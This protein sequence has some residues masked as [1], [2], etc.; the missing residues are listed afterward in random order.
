MPEKTRDKLITVANELFYE[1]GFHAVGLDQVLE[2]VGVTKT[3]FYNHFESKDE[4][5]IAVL[6]ERDR[7]ELAEWM[8]I[9]EQKGGDDPRARILALFDLLE[10]W[11]ADPAFKGCMFLKAAA[12]YPSPRDPVHQAAL[13]HGKNLAEA[14]KRH[15]AAAGAKDPGG[16]AGQLMMVLAGAVLNRHETGFADR[17]RTARATAGVLVDHHLPAQPVRG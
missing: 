12:E 10:D 2:R 6:L 11:L 3:T 4:L 15:A 1:H 9:T 16:L 7:I 13:V 17:A 8:R 14:L 5:V